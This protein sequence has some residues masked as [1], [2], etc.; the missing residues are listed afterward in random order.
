M[1]VFLFVVLFFG[2]GALVL[3]LLLGFAFGS[4]SRR[5]TLL[6][7]VG[8]AIVLAVL[9]GVIATAPTES[10]DDCSDCNEYFGRWF[11]GLIFLSAAWNALVCLVA[12][13][14][15]SRLRGRV[16]PAWTG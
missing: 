4:T 7:V 14:F 11:N 15:G 12:V 13:P 1:Q 8:V 9:I 2:V 16:D 3:G 6:C 10:P 5:I